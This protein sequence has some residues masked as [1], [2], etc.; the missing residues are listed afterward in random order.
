MNYIV[1]HIPHNCRLKLALAKNFKEKQTMWALHSV[2]NI[3]SNI[4]YCFSPSECVNLCLF[5]F[6]LSLIFHLNN[7]LLQNLICTSNLYNCFI[8]LLFYKITHY[9]KIIIL[10]KCCMEKK[11]NISELFVVRPQ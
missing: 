2:T 10:V 11:I 6:K 1:C 9:T 3:D 7:V 4:P 5:L 8:H